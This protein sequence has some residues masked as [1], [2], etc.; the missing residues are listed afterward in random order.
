MLEIKVL[1]KLRH[2]SVIRLSGWF[3]DRDMIYI[4]LQHIPGRDLSKY[5]RK[6]LPSKENLYLIIQG[7]RY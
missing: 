3:E 5:F 1:C 7:K 4:V 2:R 6:K